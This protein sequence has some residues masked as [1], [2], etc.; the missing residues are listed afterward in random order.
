MV[1]MSGEATP[2][3]RLP[4][5][6][7][8]PRRQPTP[9]RDFKYAQTHD[10]LEKVQEDTASLKS[11]RDL[12][13]SRDMVSHFSGSL[14]QIWDHH[15]WRQHTSVWRFAW[16]LQHWRHSTVLKRIAA[17]LCALVLY[18]LAARWVNEHL[19]PGRLALPA[20]ALSLQGASIGLLLVFRTNAAAARVV[21]SRTL[22]GTLARHAVDIA[23]LV[24]VEA[25]PKH[26][27]AV[28]ATAR[29]LAASLWVLKGGL[30]DGEAA[31]PHGAGGAHDAVRVLLGERDA[32]WLLREREAADARAPPGG[33]ASFRRCVLRLRQITA[34]LALRATTAQQLDV[35]LTGM[36][37]VAGGCFRLLNTPIP[38]TYQRHTTRAILV[39]L[40]ALP[41]TLPAGLGAAP[42][43]WAVLS[44]G[45]LMIGIDEI[46]I[47]HELPFAVLPLHELCV[48]SSIAVADAA[49]LPPLALPESLAAAVS[50]PVGQAVPK[51]V[52]HLDLTNELES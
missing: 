39:W 44:T 49:A 2:L 18:A 12:T 35:A 27:D 41:L 48:A 45:W 3:P 40:A 32:A 17:P 50:F 26:A 9:T 36:H 8:S 4:V 25:P 33:V 46:A 1:R 15:A 30:R 13:M 20:G 22:W 10:S 21:E 16:H 14:M 11:L 29:L 43:A 23:Q 6:T 5:V 47:Q 24:A 7:G 28:C 31:L 37:A 51:A 52:S 38:P 19:L 42:V 34:A